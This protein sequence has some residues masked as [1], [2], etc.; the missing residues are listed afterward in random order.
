M[1]MLNIVKKILADESGSMDQM[2]WL[3]GSAVVVVLVVVI[4]M[5]NSKTLAGTWWTGITNYIQTNL[6]F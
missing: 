2:V 5:A 6:G 3:L 4:L 1:K